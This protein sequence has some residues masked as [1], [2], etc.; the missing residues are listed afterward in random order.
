MEI[1][2][3][4]LDMFLFEMATV[5]TGVNEPIKIFV[6]YDEKRIGNPYFKVINAKK[7]SAATK[8]ARISF[9]EPK[10]IIHNKNYGKETWLLDS[11]DRRL[12]ISI[13][14]KKQKN[15]KTYWEEAIL[16]YNSECLGINPDDQYDMTSEQLKQ[17]HGL[18]LD[19]PM[20]DYTQ[21]K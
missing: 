4:E 16:Q 5:Y 11:H 2:M 15:G 19:T 21:L 1:N 8:M 12:L 17:L 3:N 6:S 7:F 10:Y 9:E 14:Q 13:L 20:P 18:P